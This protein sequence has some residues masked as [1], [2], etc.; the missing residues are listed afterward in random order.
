MFLVKTV[1][2]FQDWGE[3][4]DEEQVL[5]YSQ[6]RFSLTGNTC[7]VFERKGHRSVN[8]PKM[9]C[10]EKILAEEHCTCRLCYLFCERIPLLV[11]G[12]YNTFIRKTIGDFRDA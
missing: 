8:T 10:H 12:L 1:V 7:Y 5:K 2:L 4:K 3:T 11:D 6:K 9:N